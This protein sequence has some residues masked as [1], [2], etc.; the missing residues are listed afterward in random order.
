MKVAG[1]YGPLLDKAMS[2]RAAMMAAGGGGALGLAA[3]GNVGSGEAA[4][5]SGGRQALEGIGAAALGIGAGAMLPGLR[6]RSA[7]MVGDAA[8]NFGDAAQ[9]VQSP[10]GARQRAAA[11]MRAGAYQGMQDAGMTPEQAMGAIKNEMRAG[12]VAS[13]VL[14]TAALV[15]GAGA[16][17]GQL[18]G[19]VANVGN[20]LGLSIDPEAPGSSNTQN[21]RLSMQTQQLPMY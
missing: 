19:G 6:A 2:D 15:G 10:M 12:Q 18:G 20:M 5:E 8:H 1:K 21:S 3:L 13:N 14:G 9:G 11:E 4:E 17:G 16:I 7:R